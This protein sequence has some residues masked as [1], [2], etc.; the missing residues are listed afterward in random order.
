MFQRVLAVWD[1]SELAEKAF[2]M[3]LD[4]AS[5]YDAEIV[6]ASVV[7]PTGRHRHEVSDEPFESE[8]ARL[9]SSFAERHGSHEEIPVTHEVI[10]G[11]DTGENLL[12]YA[13]E[14]GFDLVV[15]GHHRDPKPG[16]LVLHGVTEELISAA[17]LPVLIVGG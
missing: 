1:G 9:R 3:A 6:A 2:D 16:L 8:V 12:V 7:C 13:H 10:E 15:I 11:R 4:V 17:Q 5:T 14:H